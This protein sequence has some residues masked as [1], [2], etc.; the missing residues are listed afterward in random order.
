MYKP[1]TTLALIVT[2]FLLAAACSSEKT[3]SSEAQAASQGQAELEKAPDFEVTTIDGETVSLQQSMEEN[4]PM[5][6]YFTASWCPICAKNW[7]VLSK[8]YPEY[9]DRL[10][11]V[12]IGIDPTDDEE[13]MRKLV[14]EE[15]LT[16]PITKGQPDIMMAFDVETQATTVG[17]NPD[18]TI[19]FRKNKTVLS[20]DEYRALFNDLIN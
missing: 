8:L 2:L 9:K 16:F 7:P 4:K 17:V 1:T 10:N 3:E 15:G 5:V 14:K 13:V 19:A 18:G 12:A 20:E 11:L 6:V